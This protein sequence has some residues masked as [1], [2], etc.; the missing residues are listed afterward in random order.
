M[1]LLDLV[2]Q[3]P[4]TVTLIVPLFGRLDNFKRFAGVYRKILET[5]QNVNLI[6]S[7]S[8]EESERDDITH[9]LRDE[10]G[11]ENMV[12]KTMVVFCAI[13]FRKANCLQNAINEL[14]IGSRKSL[15][16]PSQVRQW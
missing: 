9:I 5:D 8:G 16:I 14:G 3:D 13:P 11:A 7:L 15:L 6:V 10:I 4:R 2:R 1:L 12:D